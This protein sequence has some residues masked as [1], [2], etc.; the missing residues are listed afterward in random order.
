[1]T[2]YYYT[3]R[4]LIWNR[5][6][7]CENVYQN[8]TT[9]AN[10][11]T[12]EFVNFIMTGINQRSLGLEMGAEYK[13]T[14]TLTLQL[15]AANGIHVYHNNPVFSV[16]DDNNNS[17]YIENQVAYLKD[18]HMSSGPESVA[19]LGI[20]YN[21]PKN[22][23]VSLNGNVM[24]NMYFDISPYNHTEYGML[25]YAEGDIRIEDVLRQDPLKPAFTLDFYGGV[26]HRYKGYYFLF[27][28]SVNNIL[29]NKSTVLY[30][31]DQLRFDANNP[32]MFPSKYSY[33]YGT[34]FFISLTVRK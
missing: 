20:K 17:A 14:P 33:M 9:S 24:G 28:V 30:G 22:W 25:H 13:V 16:Y 12:S 8:T 15:A 19:S 11:Y 29:N 32:D 5:S 6:F 34:N 31:Y 27:N 2:G 1:L 7:Y 4:N 3:Y 26:S 21:D 23:W 18:Y 10:S